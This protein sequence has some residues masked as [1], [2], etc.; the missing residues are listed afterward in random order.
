ME[1][2][3]GDYS[4][5]IPTNLISITDGQ[6]YLDSDLFHQG[7]KP[8][9]N[10]GI[11]VSRV[12]GKAQRPAMKKV[13]LRLRMELAQYRDVAAFAQ[14]TSDLDKTTLQ[15]LHRGE[16]LVE[17]LKQPQHA[18]LA[19]DKQV[20]ILWAAA[21]DQLDDIPLADIATFQAQWF[22]LLDDAY[23]Q[24][25]E[26]IRAAGDLTPAVEAAL[27]ASLAQLKTIFVVSGTP[28]TLSAQRVVPKADD[29]DLRVPQAAVIAG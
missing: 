25:G 8:A 24:V 22:R 11:S 20:C 14:L 3:Q 13:A 21:H 18:P 28:E 10:V 5:Y 23:P 12:G 16:R 26:G 17:I 27:Q 2:Q 15:Q 1:T 9:I 7:F 29:H 6:I 4:A 19:L